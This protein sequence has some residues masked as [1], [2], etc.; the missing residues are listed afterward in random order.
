MI[1]LF[2]ALIR[3]T[4]NEAAESFADRHGLAILRQQ[5]NDSARAVQSARKAVA[6][7][8]AQNKQEEEQYNQIVSR[9]ND[10]EE[11]T[12]IAL[13]KGKKKIAQEAA[14]TIALLEAERDTSKEALS[15]FQTEI[16]R[17]KRQVRGAE[18]RLRELRRGQRIADVTD[19]TQR[20]RGE[21][22]PVAL[23]TLADAEETL[24]RLRVRQQQ[25]DSTAEAIAELDDEGCSD[26]IIEKLAEAGCG[27]ALKTSA[28]DV[29]ERLS[30]RVSKS[31]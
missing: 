19:K 27:A 20:M 1:K 26:K 28:D 17:L 6:I 7:A 18:T 5:I 29:L 11:R 30:K 14:E 24:L 4:A 2:Y 16:D 22:E 15:R 31:D 8:I 21:G 23:S 25:I 3:G 9:L 10:L 12:V 13:E